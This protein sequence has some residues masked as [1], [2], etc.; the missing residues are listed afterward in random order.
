MKHSIFRFRKFNA[1][2][3]KANKKTPRVSETFFCVLYYSKWCVLWCVWF[4][5]L[6]VGLESSFLLYALGEQPVFL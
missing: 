2:R 3:F 6:S 4:S 1:L 5:Y